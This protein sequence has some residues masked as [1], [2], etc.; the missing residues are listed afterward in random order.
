MEIILL[1]VLLFLAA[2]TAASETSIVAMSRLRLKK[3]AGEGSRTARVILKILETPER[4]FGTIL[5]ANNVVD[6]LIAALVTALMISLTGREGRGVLI[7]TIVAA[8][9]IIIAEVSAKT[10]AVRH[11][12]RLSL[13]LGRPIQLLI[14]LFSPLVKVLSLITNAIVR[15][16][17]GKAK[18]RP[19]LVTEEEIQALIKIGEEE[20]IRQRDKYRML[21]KVFDFSNARVR[22]VMVPRNQMVSL[23]L[24]ARIDDIL[25]RAME[26][27]YSRLPV[28]QGRPENV[29]GII[30]MK[31]LLNLAINRELIVLPD[32]IF[33]P[34]FVSGEKKAFELLREFQEGHTHLAVVKDP[35]GNIEGIVTMEDLLEEIVGEI[36]DEYDQ[37]K[38]T[39]FKSKN[40][41]PPPAAP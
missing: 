3:L 9:T 5:V 1:L 34:V 13:L 2:V 25:E 15:L 33:P 32:I 39:I 19:S 27:G 23:D 16:I 41:P 4:F 31:D 21:R 37:R 30:N 6:T 36:K 10:L 28:Y 11:P 24:N 22:D 18:G 7:A 8:S 40:K 12:E 35:K 20:D 38:R 17:G 14:I 29:V 26:S